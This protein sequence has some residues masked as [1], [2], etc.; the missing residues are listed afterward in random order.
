MTELPEVVLDGIEQDGGL[1]I[2]ALVLDSKKTRRYR[3]RQA[4]ATLVCECDGHKWRHKCRHVDLARAA[5]ETSLKDLEL[6]VTFNLAVNG[7]A[8]SAGT[9]V[10][11]SSLPDGDLSGAEEAC[12]LLSRLLGKRVHMTAGEIKE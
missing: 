5:I 1:T 12:A 11:L 3:V 6:L 8:V 9:P 4:E 7:E 2:M 10:R